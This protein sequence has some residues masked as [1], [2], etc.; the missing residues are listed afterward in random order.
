MVVGVFKKSVVYFNVGVGLSLLARAAVLG[1]TLNIIWG[2]MRKLA[3]DFRSDP[4]WWFLLV[5]CAH[6]WHHNAME[7][8]SAE[9]P[10]WN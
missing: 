9:P 5:I 3:V 2:E 8:S 1:A 7:I 10:S 4:Y 6:V